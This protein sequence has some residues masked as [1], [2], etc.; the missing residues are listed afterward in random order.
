MAGTMTF[1]TL[2]TNLRTAMSEYVAR[3]P[4]LSKRYNPPRKVMENERLAASCGRDVNY[5]LGAILKKKYIADE[6]LNYVFFWEFDET[7]QANSTMTIEDLNIFKT[8][9][10]FSFSLNYNH[11]EQQ[12]FLL[13]QVLSVPVLGCIGFDHSEGNTLTTSHVFPFILKDNTLILLETYDTFDRYRLGAR[14]AHIDTIVR[15]LDVIQQ[16][17][18][19]KTI[20]LDVSYGEKITYGD[21]FTV[22]R[23]VIIDAEHSYDLQRK[24]TEYGMGYCPMWS[25]ILLKRVSVLDLKK[26]IEEILT[27]IQGI[28]RELDAQLDTPE[29]LHHLF[30]EFYGSVSGGRRRKTRRRRN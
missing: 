22:Y 13:A 23:P 9:G 2:Y 8:N 21:A 17:T 30:A 16:F 15:G 18:V 26:P 27:D 19:P 7:K 20:T 28:Y 5:L 14:I 6:T 25:T 29:G 24:D 4:S 3:I 1:G 10:R 12:L 11:I